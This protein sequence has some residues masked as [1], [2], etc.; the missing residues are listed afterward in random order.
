MER[1]QV[2]LVINEKEFFT[3]LWFIA[4]GWKGLSVSVFNKV[5]F[6]RYTTMQTGLVKYGEAETLAR[7]CFFNVIA[8]KTL[9]IMLR[10]KSEAICTHSKC[11]LK[12]HQT[13]G[14]E[15]RDLGKTEC[16]HIADDVDY[17]DRSLAERSHDLT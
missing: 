13:D 1:E 16:L 7:C 15:S 11:N 12:R 4:L 8:R 2:F 5:P 6:A 14:K 3:I 10:M 9:S 17:V